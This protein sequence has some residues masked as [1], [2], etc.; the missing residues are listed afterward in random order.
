M[1]LVDLSLYKDE[2]QIEK[3]GKRKSLQQTT[4]E[5]KLSTRVKELDSDVDDDISEGDEDYQPS[6]K[7]KKTV[8]K[9]TLTPKSTVSDYISILILS[10]VYSAKQQC[11]LISFSQ[12]F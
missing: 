2:S 6:A 4:A 8:K 9:S 11:Q 3:K 1:F 12:I 5:K 10:H 7:K